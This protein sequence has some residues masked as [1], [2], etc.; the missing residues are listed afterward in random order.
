MMTQ[1]MSDKMERIHREI[2]T[3]EEEIRW[4]HLKVEEREAFIEQLEK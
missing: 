3:K 2:F 1:E 4:L